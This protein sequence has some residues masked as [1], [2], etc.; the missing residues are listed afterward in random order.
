[1]IFPDGSQQQSE[2]SHKQMIR[3]ERAEGVRS[4]VSGDMERVSDLHRSFRSNYERFVDLKS[5]GTSRPFWRVH[6]SDI[7]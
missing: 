1:M 5:E 4:C 3:V 2:I 6:R 7:L